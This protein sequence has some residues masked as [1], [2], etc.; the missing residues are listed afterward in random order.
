MGKEKPLLKAMP[1][2]ACGCIKRDSGQVAPVLPV[3]VR[4]YQR[5][6]CGTRLNDFQSEPAGDVIP[7]GRS[8]DFRNRQSSGSDNNGVRLPFAAGR[9]NH[10]SLRAV[11]YI[12]DAAVRHQSHGGLTALRQEHVENATRRT[13]AKELSQFLLVPW[14]PILLDQG[15][16]I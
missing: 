16:K 7:E 5:N 12:G 13:V 2:K 9:L 4:E 14:N 3:S 11:S 10:E 6:E 1:P 8:S 15:N